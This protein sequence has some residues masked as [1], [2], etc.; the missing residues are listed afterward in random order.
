M[1]TALLKVVPILFAASTTTT[2]TRPPQKAQDLANNFQ[3]VYRDL[4][5]PGPRSKH[6]TETMRFSYVSPPINGTST[7]TEGDIH[8]DLLP[9]SSK[10]LAVYIPGL[11]GYGISAHQF[12]FDDLATS[13]EFWRF[14]VMPEDR[15]SFTEIVKA[16]ADFIEEIGSEERPVT[17]IGESCG[18]LLSSAVALR[19][20]NRKS[21][22]LKGLVMVNPATSFDQTVWDALVPV[23]TSLPHDNDAIEQDRL[24]PYSVVGSLVLAYLIPDNDQ[25]RRILNLILDLPNIDIPL[26]RRDQIQDVVNATSDGF[27]GMAERL[28]PELLEHRVAKWLSVGSSVMNSRLG[29]LQIQT[30]VVVG[31]EDKLMPSAQEVDR[32][33]NVLP[34]SEKL[35]V[36][37]RGH[38]VLDDSVN[39]TEAILYSSIDPLNW[40]ETKK[41]YDII[42][43]WKLPPPEKIKDTIEKTVDPLRTIHSPVYFSSDE[44]GKR[45]MGLS[46]LPETEGPLLIVANHQF[47]KHN[48]LGQR[49][50]RVESKLCLILPFPSQLALT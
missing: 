48:L 30:L 50:E 4:E 7:W 28:P 27:R 20:Q 14:L 21:N 6:V 42:R 44:K 32:L 38:F 5:Q 33:M 31:D 34:S 24:T 15:S 3:Q 40:K 45:W 18:G 22:V 35:V 46:K 29:E 43:D 23:L 8:D 39:L 41:P 12:Q 36:R 1:W 49:F 2:T 25:Q 26:T 10:P 16:I 9:D 13:F 47:G 11:D 17:L 37:G 19:L